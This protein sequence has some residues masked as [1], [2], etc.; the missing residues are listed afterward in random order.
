M[1][2]LPVPTLNV[3]NFR[4][5]KGDSSALPIELQDPNTGDPFDPTDWVLVFTVK[6]R[7]TVPD[8][9]AL[10]QKISIV[11]GITV[12]NAAQGKITVQLLVPDF[13]HI[14]PERMYVF[15]VR[16]Q[17]I[18]DPELV[19][20]VAIGTIWFAATPTHEATLSVP[21]YT[22][23]PAALI[24]AINSIVAESFNYL[25]Y[26]LRRRTVASVTE[27]ESLAMNVLG[28]GE[29]IDFRDGGTVEYVG[30][31][32]SA[33]DNVLIYAPDTGVGRYHRVFSGPVDAGWA[34][35]GSADDSI[36]IQR[37]LNAA[38]GG[39]LIFPKG[40]YYYST[41]LIVPINTE[42]DLTGV[43]LRYQGTGHAITGYTPTADRVAATTYA[44]TVNT[45]ES[46]QTVTVSTGDAANLSAGQM[47]QIRDNTAVA[48]EGVHREM[49]IIKSVDNGTGIITLEYPLNFA[50]LTANS[51]YIAPVVPAEN[52][53]I[54][55][56]KVD[57]TGVASN[58]GGADRDAFYFYWG[59]NIKVSNFEVLNFPN[60]A[61]DF[62]GCLDCSAEFGTVSK[63]SAVGAGEG[64]SVRET[65]S[66]DCTFS[67]ITAFN[68]RHSADITGGSDCS[69]TR[70]RGIGRT[71]SANTGVFAHGCRSKRMTVTDCSTLNATQGFAFGNGTFD[72][73]AGFILS[74]FQA[75]GCDIGVFAGYGSTG[76]NISDG[77]IKNSVIRGLVMQGALNG[78]ISSVTVDGVT[79]NPSNY[80]A[81][82]I[83]SSSDGLRFKSIYIR[84]LA[85]GYNALRI[86]G[87]GNF[88]FDDLSID[89][90]GSSFG[91]NVT[92]FTGTVTFNR[93]EVIN[94]TTN[95]TV[96]LN[97][98]G[99]F[100][101]NGTV[102]RGVGATPASGFK[103]TGGAAAAIF[104]KVSVYTAS[105]GVRVENT[106]SVV[107]EV[108]DS[109]LE[110]CGNG[111][112]LVATMAA[113]RVFGNVFVGIT[114]NKLFNSPSAK[115]FGDI[116]EQGGTSADRGDASATLTAGADEVEQR[117]DTTLTANRSITLTTTAATVYHGAKFRIV[118]TGLGAFTL[119]VGS[120][121]TIP[122]GTAAWVEVTYSSTA[123]AWVLSGYGTL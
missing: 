55:G 82:D 49:S 81:V 28:D 115:I 48:G 114:G 46:A 45:T 13:E 16:A 17:N 19:Y 70:I 25:P 29:L 43:T 47:V 84:S 75:L 11:E 9:E 24:N 35:L 7:A 77:L 96:N 6:R 66:R 2:L 104:R 60:K 22:V 64:Y 121:K 93:G 88:V 67:D 110:A 92:S 99:S 56:G 51:A 109:H 1:P 123:G 61:L 122:S 34:G 26:N 113:A 33:P 72:W 120:V 100:L 10:I 18:D 71:S 53:T 103:C 20:T 85:A 37:A 90:Q 119:A 89:H 23:S 15:D 79:T 27:L 57:M 102:A 98:T 91:V 39:K 83:A 12:T 44:L 80:G 54:Y 14:Y 108:S 52:I 30:D 116:A 87:S 106:G 73:D 65:Y 38:A 76:F 97:G 21:T 62:Y 117:W 8:Q 105:E 107:P 74:G 50:Y 32:V 63:P 59:K 78:D 36:A 4:R 111:I 68:C 40:T 42:V 95:D 69:F 101:I 3:N 5:Y 31:S 58:P 118:R 94:R 112:R 86:H 41:T